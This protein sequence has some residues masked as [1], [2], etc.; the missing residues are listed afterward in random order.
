MGSPPQHTITAS[1]GGDNN[2]TA[3][4]D[5]SIPLTIMMAMPTVDAPN[6]G[7]PIY[8]QPLTCTTTVR[9][10]A[11]GQAPTGTPCLRTLPATRRSQALFTPERT[12]VRQVALA[13]PGFWA[14]RNY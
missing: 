10:V 6:C 7:S 5:V 9:G 2:Y 1:Y 12:R 13:E 3:P 4:G 14:V 11:N 8:G